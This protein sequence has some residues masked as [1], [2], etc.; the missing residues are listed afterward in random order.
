MI[1]LIYNQK[2][3]NRTKQRKMRYGVMSNAEQLN[4]YIEELFN[5]WNGE[6]DDFEPIPISEEAEKEALKDSF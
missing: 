1:M 3:T 6:N 4:E 2:E 5:Y